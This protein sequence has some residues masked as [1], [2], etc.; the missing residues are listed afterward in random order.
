MKVN[1]GQ[2]Y[3]ED[4]SVVTVIPA[5]LAHMIRVNKLITFFNPDSA[6][7]LITL[8]KRKDDGVFRFWTLSLVQNAYGA[9]DDPVVLTDPDEDLQV[10]LDTDPTNPMEVTSTWGDF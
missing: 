4:T 9:F 8:Q 5:P 10:F 1:G 3:L 6:T 2:L 7:I